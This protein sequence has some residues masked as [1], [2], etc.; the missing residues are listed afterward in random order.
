MLLGMDIEMNKLFVLT[1][2]RCAESESNP[3]F[4]VAEEKRQ[5][6]LKGRKEDTLFTYN[7]LPVLEFLVKCFCLCKIFE[8]YSCALF[9]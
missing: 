4:S 3:S 6:R 1:M 9:W 5:F 2:Y 8:K 7:T